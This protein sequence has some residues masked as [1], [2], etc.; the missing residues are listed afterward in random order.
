MSLPEH[1]SHFTEPQ[2][3]RTHGEVTLIDVMGDD[4]AVVN[5]ARISYQGE[6]ITK[7]SADRH[8]IRYLMR[9]QHWTPFEMCEIKL[10]IKIPMDA[11]RQMVRH[12][13]AS[14]N[15]VSTRYSEIK[16]EFALTEASEWR[17]QSTDNRQGSSGYLEHWP[18]GMPQDLFH[19]P[20]EYLTTKE[21]N[22]LDCALDLYKERLKFGIARE[23]AR[24]DLPLSTYTEAYWKVDLRN[25]LNF[26]KLRLDSHAQQEIREFAEAIAN[27]VKAWVPWVW[28][29]FEDYHLESITLHRQDIAYLRT[30]LQGTEVQK[31]SITQVTG[32]ELEELLKKLRVF[33]VSTVEAP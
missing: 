12:R 32:R 24:K 19:S 7:R 28:E 27:I 18:E 26:L 33:G 9:H 31:A 13:T 2:R 8:L 1:L 10:R 22:F 6:N 4:M 11:W 23:Q 15:E 29:A 5:A 25:L 17:L 21:A 3:I 20:N 30:L 14:I 16:D